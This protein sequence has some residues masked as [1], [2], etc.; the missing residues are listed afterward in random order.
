VEVAFDIAR[1]DTSKSSNEFVNLTRVGTTDGIGDTDT[2]DTDLVDGTV[3]REEVD[4]VGSERVLGRETNFNSLGL[5]EFDDFDSGLDDVGDVLSV[6]VL[7]EEGRGTDNDIDTIDTFISRAS[8][9]KKSQKKPFETVKD[10]F[11]THQ[12][13]QRA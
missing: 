1:Y 7:A 2:V 6:G 3:D 4:E 10:S 13:R 9:K 11:R 12:S 8:S 5:D